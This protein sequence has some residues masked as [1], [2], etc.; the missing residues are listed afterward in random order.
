VKVLRGPKKGPCLRWHRPVGGLANSIAA[1]LATRFEATVATVRRY[2]AVAQIEEWAKICRIDSDA[3]DTMWASSLVSVRDDS[4]DATYY[5]MLVDKFAN[6]RRRAPNYEL[7]TFYGQPQHIF[8]IHFI[9]ACPDLGLQDP[10]TI[11]LAAMRSCVLD[12]ASVAEHLDMHS[13]S[14]EGPLHFLDVLG[15]QCLIGQVKDGNRW[16]IIDRSGSLARAL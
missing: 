1:A 9:T 15:I 12:D 11:F 7:Q 2:L 3:G 13:Y 14:K 4:R 6:W 8:T 16:M 10:T 5:E